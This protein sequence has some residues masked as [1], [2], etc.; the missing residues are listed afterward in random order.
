TMFSF[1]LSPFLRTDLMLW[2]PTPADGMQ[3]VQYRKTGFPDHLPH[4]RSFFQYLR[5][6]N[7]Y[8][9]RIGTLSFHFANDGEDH[10]LSQQFVVSTGKH[11][12]NFICYSHFNVTFQ[13]FIRGKQGAHVSVHMGRLKPKLKARSICARI[14]LSTSSAVACCSTSSTVLQRFPSLSKIG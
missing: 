2:L 1:V 14:S 9:F 8:T 12:R 5:L 4:R 11:N 10:G 6:G 7:F 3:I 13:K